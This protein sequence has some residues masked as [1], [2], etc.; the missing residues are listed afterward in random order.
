MFVE[1]IIITGDRPRADI[2]GLADPRIADIAQMI[3]LCAFLDA[4][5]LD[6]N[7]IADFRARPDFGP[8]TQTAIGADIRMGA[9][10]AGEFASISPMR[11]STSACETSRPYAAMNA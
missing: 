3:D 10:L 8:R 4:G 5:F 6:F 1:T 7:E 11:V 9:W 2:G